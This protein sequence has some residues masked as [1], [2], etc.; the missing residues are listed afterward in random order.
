MYEFLNE[1]INEYIEEVSLDV[2]GGPSF[3]TRVVKLS[4]GGEQR[5]E[6]LSQ[7]YGAWEFG[8]KMLNNEELEIIRTFF[9][10]ARGKLIEFRFKDWTDFEV[11]PGEGF[12]RQTSKGIRLIKRYAPGIEREIPCP[13]D[14]FILKVGN[15]IRLSAS[16]NPQTGLLET[17]GGGAASAM[18]WVGE[19]DARVRFDVDSMPLTVK[20]VDTRTGEKHIWLSPLPIVEMQ[21]K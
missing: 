18:T 9:W 19:F 2:M 4:A 6:N 11:K 1:R 15:E 10:K 12:A 14:G 3:N 20:N 8:E 21:V 5:N 13:V 17:Y 7:A 16:V